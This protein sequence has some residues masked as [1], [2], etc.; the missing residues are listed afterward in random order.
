M[1]YFPKRVFDS[2]GGDSSLNDRTGHVVDVLRELTK[3]EADIADVGRMFH[4]RFADGFETD[5][6]EDEL[7]PRDTIKTIVDGK[8]VFQVVDYIPLGYVIWNIGPNMAEGYL[9]LCQVGGEDG[10]H[11]NPATLKVIKCDG[12]QTILA[13]AHCAG[14]PSA[15]RKFLS[16]HKNAKPGSYN[17]LCV[18]R[19]KAA[20]PYLDKLGW[21]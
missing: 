16:K 4:V 9:P 1:S 10:C 20:L 2:Y 18:Q 5:V 3:E 14:T 11:V 15:M 12:A 19:I 13:A 8:N 17:D 6:F 7:Y 21:T